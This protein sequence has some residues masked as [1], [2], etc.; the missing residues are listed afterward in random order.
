M[1]WSRYSGVI[2]KHIDIACFILDLLYSC[3]DSERIRDIA[4]DGN[5]HSFRRC[6][7]FD[8]LIQGLDPSTKDVDF[9]RPAFCE[10]SCN[11]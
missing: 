3:V 11:G 6:Y 10:G 2:D 8:S 4:D 1:V 5:D 7:R 9:G